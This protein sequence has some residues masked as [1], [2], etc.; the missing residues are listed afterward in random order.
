MKDRYSRRGGPKKAIGPPLNGR[1][2][3][4]DKQLQNRYPVGGRT[5]SVRERALGEVEHTL[6]DG[7]GVPYATTGPE[8]ETITS[9]LGFVYDARVLVAAVGKIF[10]AGVCWRKTS[11]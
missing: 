11:V 8:L 10:C 3:G 4:I 1:P 6:D 2:C 7:K 9:T 5:R